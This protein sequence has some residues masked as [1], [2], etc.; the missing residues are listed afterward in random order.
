MKCPQCQS[1]L[2]QTGKYWV[3][4][5]H[6]LVQAGQPSAQAPAPQ[7]AHQVFI[8]YGREDAMEFAKRLAADLKTGGHT[9]FLD[10]D[11][12]EKG[13]LWEVRIEQGIRNSSVLAAVMTPYSLRPDSVCR[14][15][16]VWA[17]NEEKYV[18]PLKANADP[19]LKP[20]LLLA[21]RNWIDFSQS[22]E[23]GLKALL[24]FLAGDLSGLLQPPLPTITGVAP[25]DFAPEIA[26]FTAGFVGRAW[27]N[28]EVDAWLANDTRRAMV[29][30]AEPGIGKSAIAAWLSQSRSDV[31]GVH[32]CTQQNSRTRDPYEFVA[33]LVGQLH[34]RLPGF[35]EK[36]EA[37]NPQVRRPT[38]SDA[39]RELIIE[40]A[41]ALP[42]PARPYLIVV[43]SLDESLN[44]AGETVLDVLVQQAS[45]LPAWLRILATSRPEEPILERIR[46][47]NVLEVMAERP[48]NLA[49]V[50]DYIV[51]RLASPAIQKQLAGDADDVAQK[52]ETLSEGNFLYA[53]MAIDALEDGSLHSSAIDQLAPGLTRF[54]LETFRRRFPD[55]E[56]F[57][58]SL[59]PLLRPL[60]AARAPLSFSMLR[61][62]AGADDEVVFRRL[63]QLR[64]YLRVFGRGEA[65]TYAVYHRSLKDWLASADDARDYWCRAESGDKALASMGWRIYKNSKLLSDDYFFRYLPDHLADAKQWEEL[66]ELLTDLDLLEVIYAKQR[67]HEWMRLWH[68]LLDSHPPAQAYRRALDAARERGASDEAIAVASERIGSLLRDLG[69]FLDAVKFAQEAVNAWEE[70]RAARA[71]DGMQCGQTKASEALDNYAMATDTPSRTAAEDIRL[72]RSLHNLAEAWRLLREFDKA[73]PCYQ[74]ALDIWRRKY[75][76]KSAEVAIVYHDFAEFYRDQ[77]NYSEAIAYNQRAMEIREKLVPL[78][79]PALADCVNDTGVLLWES[80]HGEQALPYYE[81]ALQLFYRAYP[82]REHYDIAS[83]LGNIAQVYS[84]SGNHEKALPLFQKALNM[85]LA[86]RVFHYPQCRIT[87]NQLVS[88]YSALARYEEAVEVQ[89]E[90]VR[91]SEVLAPAGDITRLRELE[92][93]AALLVLAGKANKA[94]EV[95]VRLF[96]EFISTPQSAMTTEPPSA[97]GAAQQARFDTDYLR[98]LAF[99]CFE[100]G[101]YAH[102]EQILRYML[103]QNLETASTRCHLARILILTGRE[104][105]ARQEAD[106]ALANLDGATDYVRLRVL[107]LELMFAMVGNA[108]LKPLLRQLKHGIEEGATPMIWKIQSVLDHF[109]PQ[110]GEESGRFLETLAA[111][112]SNPAE[113]DSLQNF[114]MWNQAE[115]D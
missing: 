96:D 51:Q 23:E 106:L 101:D 30:V 81:R 95:R 65:S 61:N 9:A 19:K 21:R 1:E 67:S 108:D 87:R 40:P 50:R 72:A 17:L 63:D 88:C 47:L 100:A 112:V 33:N 69:L 27:V 14:D 25:L 32:F 102:A 53:H 114:P 73:L 24:R 115:L 22:Y 110:L 111:V 7:H 103:G 11:K 55:V 48:E 113:K 12:I 10:L 26:R 85:A 92:K 2:T 62:L 97:A 71:G 52:L 79:L 46:T 16:V 6:G 18:L 39:F 56:R 99:A 68:A 104:T 98:Q 83:V 94:T 89:R 75:G 54:F 77:S 31:V 107:F 35:A 45:D 28:Q 58:Q 44:Q 36:V 84:G 43:D 42:Q 4:P 70:A 78:D 66:T 38:A 59:A 49:D 64:S 86:F 76:E 34:A 91:C 3:C 8:S 80:G 15:E 90:S 29:L 41:R 82:N 93:F 109:K 5:E 74:R 57:A 20:S 105:E 13:G 60:V 37:K